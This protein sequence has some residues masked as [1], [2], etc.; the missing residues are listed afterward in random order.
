MS[1]PRCVATAEM[2]AVIIR[3]LGEGG[4]PYEIAAELGVP[5]SSVNNRISKLRARGDLPPSTGILPPP[6]AN[7]A[8]RGPARPRIH[9]PEPVTIPC[10]RCARAF[11]TKCRIR[12]RIC[13]PCKL[14][15]MW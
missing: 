6:P 3:R 14:S 12:N 11:E 5:S 1:R 2:D 9:M 7:R 15:E 4:R 8:K 13:A 10:L